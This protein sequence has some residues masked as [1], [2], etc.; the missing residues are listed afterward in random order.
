MTHESHLC[1]NSQA[2]SS[3]NTRVR[4]RP[5]KPLHADVSSAAASVTAEQCPL[6]AATPNGWQKTLASV[7]SQAKA[8]QLR[9]IYKRI[10]TV[11]YDSKWYGLRGGASQIDLLSPRVHMSETDRALL[12]ECSELMEQAVYALAP[13]HPVQLK[14]AQLKLLYCS[15]GTGRQ[16]LHFDLGKAEHLCFSALMAGCDTVGTHLPL[17]TLAEQRSL[18]E[19]AHTDLLHH[20]LCSDQLKETPSHFTNEVVATGDIIAF[21]CDTLHAGPQNT[22][23][24]ERFMLY[25][26]FSP[27]SYREMQGQGQLQHFPCGEVSWH[28]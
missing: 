8:L 3:I 16:P 10:A 2:R 13:K 6:S 7:Q 21:R 28:S 14:L 23:D 9:H 25:A 5:L 4:R 27:H 17:A 12:Q 24:S 15:P 22:T 11:Q 18:F 26:L 1:F 20:K 19:I